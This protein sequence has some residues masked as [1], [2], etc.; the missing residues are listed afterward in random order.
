MELRRI[1]SRY[2]SVNVEFFLAERFRIEKTDC[3]NDRVMCADLFVIPSSTLY[4][5]IRFQHQ[6][7]KFGRRLEIFQ[8]PVGVFELIRRQK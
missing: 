2:Q 1:T 7:S 3:G 4:F 5:R 6:R 8:Y